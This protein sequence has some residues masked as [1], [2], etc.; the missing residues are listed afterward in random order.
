[1]LGLHHFESLVEKGLPGLSVVDDLYD[2]LYK[3]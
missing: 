3:G 1:L 2:A